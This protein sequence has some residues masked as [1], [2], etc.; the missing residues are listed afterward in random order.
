M[1]SRLN[2]GKRAPGT[3]A[4]SARHVIFGRNVLV[5]AAGRTK[6]L[7]MPA[8]S[9]T[10]P[11]RIAA[12][13]ALYAVCAGLLTLIGWAAEIQRLTAW[14]NDGI[15][16]FPNTA[17]CG[18][19]IGLA[20]LAIHWRR[21]PGVLVSRVLSALV[22]TVGLLTLVE[23][24][25][26]LN[27]G[28]DTLLFDR[29]WGQSAAAAPMRMGPPASFSFALLGLAMLLL[30]LRSKS[31]SAAVVLGIAA[32]SIAMLSL[33]GHLYGATQMFMLPHLTG[34]AMQTASVIFALGLGVVASIPEREPMR[35]ILEDSA[36]GI[37]ARRSLPVVVVL[38]LSLGWIR[39]RLQ[40]HG[41][42]DTA[43]GTALRTLVEIVLLTGLLWR[44][45]SMIRVHETALHESEN[46]VRRQ[47]G[48]L[49]GFLETA[50]IA[51]HRV[52]EDGT[53]LWANDAELKML[54][55]TREEYFGHN[56][57]DFHADRA[58]IEG[59]MNRLRAGERLLAQPAQMICRDGSIKHVLIDSSV[60][61]DEGRFLH[62][63]C[64]TRDVTDQ[65]RNEEARALLASIVRASDDAIVS[66]TLDG[67][68]TSWNRGAE[69]MFGYSEAEAV[70]RSVEMLI[71]PEGIAAER[72]ILARLRRGEGIEHYETVRLT[73][74]GKRIDISL[75]VSPIRDVAG[76]PVAASSSSRNIS[77]RKQAE[78]ER[79]EASRRKDEFIAI[80]AHELRNPLAP[81]RN[82]AYFLKSIPNPEIQRPV[83]MI[84][85]QVAQMSRLIDDLLDVSRISRG[86]L[87][88]RKER[89]ACG[90]IVDAA[91]E[92]CREELQAKKHKLQIDVP[93]PSLTFEAD[94]E[95]LVQVLSNLLGNA[96]KYTPPGGN[97]RLTVGTSRGM[98]EMSVKDDGIGIPPEKL[99]QIFELFV[100]VDQSLERQ[101]GL[102]IG[103]TLARQIVELHGGTI[104]ARSRG[105]G[106]GSEFIVRLPIVAAVPA[107]VASHEGNGSMRVIPR[108]VLIADDN[109]D[110]AESLAMLLQF[111]G[112][113][114]HTAFDG[115]AALRSAERLLPDVAL[116][117][118]G[119]P[120]ANGY[121][122]AQRIR[123]ESWGSRI[124]LVAL[125][126]WGQEADRQRAKDAGFDLH[127]LKPVS[128]EAIEELLTTLP[129]T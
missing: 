8:G 109:Q 10:W 93:S 48:Q 15:S 38:A 65:R 88:L 25:T 3:I 82:A 66:K 18:V 92:A 129:D 7:A 115:E 30:P 111:E 112:H 28:I 29:P 43:F 51:L 1:A 86:V 46:E 32:A 70:G 72:A 6:M 41:I 76:N 11:R 12:T 77:D 85:R 121:E 128:P 55:Y 17:F 63:Q 24:L 22:V 47:A 23:H 45:L 94:R 81:V 73:K 2:G 75:T 14:K 91:V 37:L 42:V 123:E 114:V 52:A 57:V 90:E 95:R 5:H 99:S 40:H 68:I 53:I 87:E 49:G 116:I 83:E 103:L 78:A 9:Q 108:R 39:V 126:G 67:I 118:I 97:L 64:F 27:F 35:T 113:D 110:A 50:A 107:S 58:A 71:P 105:V 101:G 26:D 125:T 74:T 98:F 59:M 19:A 84:E 127:M 122:V 44:A 104:E 96:A 119:M 102:G 61:R 69:R 33:I 21:E 89:V 80:L 106:R 56:I 60:L 36:A 62:T 13:A 34:I 79:E 4:V 31:R 20:L 100:R 120:K 124:Y 54:G 117:D 16:M